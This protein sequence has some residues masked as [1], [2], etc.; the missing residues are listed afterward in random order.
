[1]TDR[2]YEESVVARYSTPGLRRNQLT[3]SAK[4]LMMEFDA[5]YSGMSPAERDQFLDQMFPEKPKRRRGQRV[6]KNFTESPSSD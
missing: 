1:M 4:K 6:K 3:R 2:G 5:Q